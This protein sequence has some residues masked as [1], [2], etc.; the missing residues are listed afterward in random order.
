MHLGERVTF[1]CTWRRCATH[2]RSRYRLLQVN[3]H[4]AIVHSNEFDRSRRGRALTSAVCTASDCRCGSSGCLPN[5]HC[6]SIFQVL[7]GG[8]KHGAKQGTSDLHRNRVSGLVQQSNAAGVHR[9]LYHQLT[10]G[11]SHA[12][13]ECILDSCCIGDA[14]DLWIPEVTPSIEGAEP[15]GQGTRTAAGD[16]PHPSSAPPKTVLSGFLSMFRM[17]LVVLTAVASLKLQDA[18]THGRLSDKQVMH[19]RSRDAFSAV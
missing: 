4:L 5:G 14:S 7:H 11:V 18:A 17:P 6:G 15:S 19:L 10:C 2:L 16:R 12:L 9:L 13:M 3:N 8:F 1:A